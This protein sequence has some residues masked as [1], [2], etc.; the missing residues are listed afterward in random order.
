MVDILPLK[1]RESTPI[2][3]TG[4]VVSNK[5]KGLR[6]IQVGVATVLVVWAVCVVCFDV[7]SFNTTKWSR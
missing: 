7:K 6:I 3:E 5:T 1:Q 2:V 4:N